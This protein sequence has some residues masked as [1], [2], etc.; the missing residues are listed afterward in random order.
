L[1]HVGELLK[2][3]SDDQL[4]ELYTKSAWYFDRKYGKPGA[5]YEAFK[6]AVT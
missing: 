1:R 4:E 6:H 3:E 2:Y 5:A